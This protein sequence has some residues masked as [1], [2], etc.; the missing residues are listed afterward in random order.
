MLKTHMLSRTLLAT[1]TVVLIGAVQAADCKLDPGMKALCE[2]GDGRY[3]ETKQDQT[4]RFGENAQAHF[5][6]F[7]CGPCKD[8][9]N[10]DG[11]MSNKPGF[12]KLKISDPVARAQAQQAQIALVE[13]MMRRRARAAN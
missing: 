8:G 11:P 12:D 13:K 5:V 3:Q 10:A 9:C 6:R 7:D 2:D 1:L 4:C